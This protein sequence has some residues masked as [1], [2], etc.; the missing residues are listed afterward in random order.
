MSKKSNILPTSN[1][2]TH[3]DL[4]GFILPSLA[5][6]PFSEKPLHPYSLFLWG[7]TGIGKSMAIKDFGKTQAAQIERKFVEWNSLPRQT[8]D[9]LLDDPS[10]H[11]IFADIRLS[12]ADPS[13]VKGIPSLLSNRPAADWK[14][15]A[16]FA[17]LSH[18]KATGILF[19][20]EMNLAPPSIQAAAYQII[21]DRQVGENP[22]SD[23]IL[24]IAA[25]NLRSDKA[26]LFDMAGPLKNRFLHFS[27]GLPSAEKWALWASDNELDSRVSAFLRYKPDLLFHFNQESAEYAF[28]T[29]RAWHRVADIIRNIGEPTGG[30]TET[31]LNSIATMT[32]ASVGAGAA[33]EFVA[34]LKVAKKINIVSYLKNPKLVEELTYQQIAEK[35]ALISG[36]ANIFRATPVD[37]LPKV[38]PSKDKG[39][40]GK[41]NSYDT[42]SNFLNQATIVANK[43]DPEFGILLMRLVKGGEKGTQRF[44]AAAA[45]SPALA[46]FTKK[47]LDFI[48]GK[49]ENI[50]IS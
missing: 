37:K 13:D 41:E 33:G 47:H 3:E 19:F 40:K 44:V 24:I 27:L 8:K 14:P 48:A 10:K 21:N 16:L 49:F 46:E 11:F 38:S 9:E 28:P 42:D 36:I 25:G 31:Q 17:A 5:R 23:K 1:E 15:M 6:M 30:L 29:P 50:K 2:I 45:N 4:T 32:E 26:N 12:Q 35:W 22:L 34:F 43:L 20:D 18:P 39:T 7:R